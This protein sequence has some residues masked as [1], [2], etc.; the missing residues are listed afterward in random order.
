MASLELFSGTGNASSW[1]L[2]AWLALREAGL[3]FEEEIVDIRR[4]Q[5]FANLARIGALSPAASVPV[6]MIGKTA[7]FDSLAIMEYANDAADGQ[8][9]PG[10]A[11]ARAQARSVLAWRHAGL[12]G[13]CARISFESA[14]YPLKRPLTA[15]EQEECARLFDPLECY[16]EA[17]GDPY[18]FGALSL[19]DIA[20]VPTVIRLTRHGADLETRLRLRDW[21]DALLARP[22]LRDW[23]ADAGALPH[24][25]FDDYLAPGMTADMLRPPGG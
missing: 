24:I 4:P 6:L 3:E 1:A 11:T 17:H 21:S 20:L 22:A 23:M 13:L 16:L 25:W 18:L 15:A 10:D 12:S 2:R 7:V 19:A 14:F 8:L 5:R 9:L